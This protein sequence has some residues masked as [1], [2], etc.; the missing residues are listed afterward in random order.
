M[1][2]ALVL[3]TAIL[4]TGA[5]SAEAVITT[6][7]KIA[8]R[9]EYYAFCSKHAVPSP[10]LTSCMRGVQDQLSAG[11]L[12]ALVAAGEVTQADIAAYEARKKKNK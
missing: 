2:R 12:K 6:R 11:C 5:V 8:C 3:G 10:G 9:S 7:V 4:V 1:P